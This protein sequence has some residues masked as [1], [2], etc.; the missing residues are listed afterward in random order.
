VLDCLKKLCL[1]IAHSDCLESRRQFLIIIIAA[2]TR[3]Q[4]EF[5]KII[6]IEFLADARAV[7]EDL[8]ARRTT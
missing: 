6:V 1:Q 8:E 2:P 7:G 4:S 5:T 3:R